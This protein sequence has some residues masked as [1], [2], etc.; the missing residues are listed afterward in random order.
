MQA[1]KVLNEELATKSLE[2]LGWLEQAVK[3]TANF[4]AEQTPLYIS[5][6]LSYNFYT[7]LATFSVFGLLIIA[8]V[9]FSLTW[10]RNFCKK[11]YEKDGDSVI[12]M[13][14]L[15]TLT[16]VLLLSALTCRN[17]DWIKIK[18]APRVYVMEYLKAQIKN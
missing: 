17:S 18:L 14:Y 2:L 7:S 10:Q 13:T 15:I 3:S 12:Y 1:E 11:E 4:T 6:L 9:I 8:V 16:L 5:E